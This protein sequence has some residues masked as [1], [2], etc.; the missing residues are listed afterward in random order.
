MNRFKCRKGGAPFLLLSA[1]AFFWMT[2]CA[3]VT[4]TDPYPERGP[5]EMSKPMKPLK[6][7]ED[8]R[9]APSLSKVPE[10]DLTLDRVIEIAI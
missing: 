3:L 6:G 9:S 1:A 5:S 2:G 8:S 7:I 10:Q 4:L